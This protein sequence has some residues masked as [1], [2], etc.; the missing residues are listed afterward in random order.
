MRTDERVMKN[1]Y[2]PNSAVRKEK[3]TRKTDDVSF[4]GS[5]TEKSSGP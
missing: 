3:E 2:C 1:G 4:D 5:M